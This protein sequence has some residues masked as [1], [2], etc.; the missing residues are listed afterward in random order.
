[1]ILIERLSTAY[2]RYAAV[3]GGFWGW[4]LGASVRGGGPGQ[5]K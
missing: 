3:V 4:G 1:L 5:G 2:P